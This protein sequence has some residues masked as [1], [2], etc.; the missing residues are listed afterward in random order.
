MAFPIGTRPSEVR[1]ITREIC[2][3]FFEGDGARFGLQAFMATKLA[4]RAVACDLQSRA[5]GRTP[6]RE[7]DA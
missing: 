7:L 3:R 1:E 4:K 5:A 6:H 2:E